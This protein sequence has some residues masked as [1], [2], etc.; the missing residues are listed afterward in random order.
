MEITAEDIERMQK[1]VSQYDHLIFYT[2]G[3]CKGN[4]LGPQVGYG[5]CGI[6]VYG[7]QDVIESDP[8][9]P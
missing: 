7:H 1:L 4:H 8:D 3:S 5:G 6:A 9:E 2:D